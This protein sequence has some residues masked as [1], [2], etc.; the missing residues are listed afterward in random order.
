MN[1]LPPAR[2]TYFIS[3]A[4][5]EKVWFRVSGSNNCFLFSL[6]CYFCV[7]VHTL[8]DVS[9]FH[10]VGILPLCWN[11]MLIKAAFLNKL[12][13][14]LNCHELVTETRGFRSRRQCKPDYIEVLYIERK[15]SPELSISPISISSFTF[16]SHC[17]SF[18]G[19]FLPTSCI[20]VSSLYFREILLFFLVGS[21]VSNRIHVT[22]R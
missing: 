17:I 8:C 3:E 14:R 16:F 9:S 7:V 19:P 22:A 10:C 21:S 6:R 12:G 2:L 15:S 18:S 4:R 20:M 5:R 13:G 11:F 1:S